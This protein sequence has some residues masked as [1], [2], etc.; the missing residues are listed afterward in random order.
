MHTAIRRHGNFETVPTEPSRANFVN[1]VKNQLKDIFGITLM[2]KEYNVLAEKL[3]REGA[4]SC[5]R[6]GTTIEWTTKPN[7]Q[8][9]RAI[10]Y[11]PAG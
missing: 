11:H 6:H 2:D 5:V 8:G 3:F 10:A 7:S 4:G 1:S 9:V